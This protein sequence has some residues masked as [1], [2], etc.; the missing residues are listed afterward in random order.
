MSCACFCVC[1]VDDLLPP[2]ALQR[3]L[4]MRASAFRHVFLVLIVQVTSAQAENDCTGLSDG[5]LNFQGN[6]SSYASTSDELCET[7][8]PWIRAGYEQMTGNAV[9]DSVV[10][11][12]WDPVYTA[13]QIPFF[14]WSQPPAG[15]FATTCEHYCCVA[16]PVID[17]P[18]PPSP[19]APPAWP[20][21]IDQLPGVSTNTNAYWCGGAL[22]TCAYVFQHWRGDLSGAAYC[23]TPVNKRLG[24]LWNDDAPEEPIYTICPG[25]C[26]NFYRGACA[27]PAPPSPPMPPRLPPFA[28]CTDML[29][30]LQTS[31]EEHCWPTAGE[32]RRMEG[33]E[34]ESGPVPCTCAFIFANWRGTMDPAEYCGLQVQDRL[35]HLWAQPSEIPQGEIFTICPSTC[36]SYYRGPCAPPAPPKPPPSP[37]TPPQPPPAPPSPPP[38]MPPPLWGPFPDG[39][40]GILVGTSGDGSQFS[41]KMRDRHWFGGASETNP[42]P[43]RGGNI[44]VA[45]F[46]N[47]KVPLS[48]GT[49]LKLG[50][51]RHLTI[52]QYPGITSPEG[53]SWSAGLHINCGTWKADDGPGAKIVGLANT[54]T[55]SEW[56]NAWTVNADGTISPVIRLVP[57]TAFVLGWGSFRQATCTQ[58]NQETTVTIENATDP[59]VI[60]LYFTPSAPALYFIDQCCYNSGGGGGRR[61]QELTRVGMSPLGGLNAAMQSSYEAYLA[62]NETAR[63]LVAPRER[64]LAVVASKPRRR[65]PL[66]GWARRL[67][68]LR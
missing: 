56:E 28:P 32:G 4:R 43:T 33:G 20:P 59:T 12:N 41:V 30:A 7:F 13:P 49:E 44:W 65:L 10:C 22:C 51:S 27:P 50:G 21:C 5:D 6:F 16:G 66:P 39:M 47:T 68:R 31:T 35:G 23:D 9:S 37:P 26:A 64:E 8:I 45:G 2:R 63:A 54:R 67:L 57:Q 40:V 29:P 60:K 1:A 18:E 15:S 62:Q 38:P 24:H 36:A 52:P 25:T 42:I 61:A 53:S 11:H 19:P 17:P 34:G 14:T 55:W 58:P 3:I 48:Q 46:R